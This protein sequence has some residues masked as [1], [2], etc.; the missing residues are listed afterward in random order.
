[1]STEHQVLLLRCKQEVAKRNG[2]R[3]TSCT[4]R[5]QNNV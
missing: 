2:F 5:D 3:I 1:L 4:F